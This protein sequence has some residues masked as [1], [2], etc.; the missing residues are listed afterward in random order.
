MVS[1]LAFAALVLLVAQLSSAVDSALTFDMAAAKN[2]VSKVITLLKDILKE[3]DHEAEKDGEVYDEISCWCETNDKEKSNNIAELESH[4]D[5]LAKSVSYWTSQSSRFTTEVADLKH[6]LA[7]EQ[8]D[9]DK[10][11]KLREEQLAEFHKEEKELVKSVQSLSTATSAMSKN[12]INFLQ[13]PD[14]HI[15]SVA[16]EVRGVVERHAHQ[17]K[18]VLTNSERR[19]VIS[20]IQI[21]KPGYTHEAFLQSWAPDKGSKKQPSGQIFG[22]LASMKETFEANLAYA[23]KQ[24]NENQKSY[25]MLKTAKTQTID[26]LQLKTE[27]EHSQLAT[28]NEKIADS[29]KEKET[30]LAAKKADVAFLQELQD[31]CAAIDDEFDQRTKTRDQEMEAISGALNVLTSDAAHDTL[32]RTFSPSLVQKQR[33]TN[34][35]RRQAASRVLALLADKVHNPR[36]ATLATDV[37]L[38]TFG[39]VRKSIIQLVDELSKKK[40]DEANL[41]DYCRDMLNQNEHSTEENKHFKAI[42]ES[43]MTD[44]TQQLEDLASET[45]AMNS[46]IGTLQEQLKL[47]GQDRAAEHKEFLQTVADQREVVK[48]LDAAYHI[49]E[50]FYSREEVLVQV[51]KQHRQKSGFA[52]R[53]KTRSTDIFAMIQE[54][55]RDAE[56][57]IH[58]VSWDEREDQKAYEELVMNTNDSIQAKRDSIQYM[59][60]IK[61]KRQEDVQDVKMELQDANNALKQV[62]NEKDT[63]HQQ[64]DFVTKNFDI[65]QKA[66]DEEVAGLNRAL[67][68]LSGASFAKVAEQTA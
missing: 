30:M 36:L 23:R 50:G 12:Y 62:S 64:C 26:K 14:T 67:A 49:L 42:D 32:A 58:R 21:E 16:A 15:K 4:L 68:I 9:L 3:I 54:V 65:R 13:M 56:E 19:A 60:E 38:D 5:Q 18:S 57:T 8:Q 25:E 35:K 51:G 10:A 59:S 61:A 28:I 66:F 37:K 24:E 17:L 52:T 44:L 55:T 48:L 33:T 27:S 7:R 40:V 6:N 34:S 53:Y 2:P 45:K 20:L 43:V 47:A 31:E 1:K 39:S 46:Q 11:T 41:K 63:L 29:A 22:T